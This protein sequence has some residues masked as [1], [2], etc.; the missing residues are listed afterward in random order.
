MLSKSY[1][2]EWMALIWLSKSGFCVNHMLIAM[3]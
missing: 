2:L 1:F 3:L